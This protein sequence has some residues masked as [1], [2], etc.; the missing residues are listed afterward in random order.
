MAEKFLLGIKDACERYSMGENGMR[1]E[2]KK[3]GAVIKLGKGKIRIIADVMD[4]SM[5]K[6]ITM[7]KW[8]Q[9][10][11]NVRNVRILKLMNPDQDK[12]IN[13]TSLTYNKVISVAK[14]STFTNHGY[15]M[16]AARG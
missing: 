8:L 9:N 16:V 3:A 4:M 15:S 10:N 13:R 14:D 7:Q 11:L 1:T 12:L 5:T 6:T 2:A